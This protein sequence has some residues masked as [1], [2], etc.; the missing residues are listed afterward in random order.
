MD[1]TC[2]RDYDVEVKVLEAKA[3]I[4]NENLPFRVCWLLGACAGL[5]LLAILAW[6][7]FEILHQQLTT[8][9]LI[10][11]TSVRLLSSWFPCDFIGSKPYVISP[12]SEP[13]TGG[14]APSIHLARW[15]DNFFEARGPDEPRI[16]L[17][18]DARASV[19]TMAFAVSQAREHSLTLPNAVFYGPP[20]T[21]KT[22][23]AKR[24][25]RSC[26]M[27]YAIM[28]GGNVIGLRHQA[29]PELRRVLR[30]ATRTR[31][32]G[33]VLF[34]DEADAF[35]AT[36]SSTHSPSQDPFVQAAMSFFLAQTGEAS[37]RLLVILA[38]N[39][40]EALDNAVISRMSYPIEFGT[41]GLVEIR[42]LLDDRLEH[43]GQVLGPAARERFIADLT[44]WAH[45]AHHWEALH[46]RGFTG[47]DVQGLFDEFA[48]Q[49]WLRE[50]LVSEDPSLVAGIGLAADADGPAWLRRWLGLRE[51]R[52]QYAVRRGTPARAAAAA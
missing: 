32:K 51:G 9:P 14:R 16:V 41:P 43:A 38:A 18:P 10:D 12:G 40:L 22:L 4:F 37:R 50:A 17:T 52:L 47:R 13:L 25:A 5:L 39:R 29:V 44:L 8:P 15:L 48:R 49:W 6:L 33:L 42:A 19:R 2:P 45:P 34:I 11:D 27:D 1:G 20:G 21:G 46:A 3:R 30:W 24:L 7:A 31:S 23:T 36:R 35:L 26:G 28:S